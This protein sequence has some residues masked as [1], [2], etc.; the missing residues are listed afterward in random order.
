MSSLVRFCNN[1]FAFLVLVCGLSFDIFVA[2]SSL[3]GVG[4]EGGGV[5]SEAGKPEG[6]MTPPKKLKGNFKISVRV[7]SRSV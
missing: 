2:E 3:V 6:K 5:R 1:L 4:R 7:G